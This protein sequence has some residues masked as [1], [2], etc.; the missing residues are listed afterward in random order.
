MPF[1]PV[2]AEQYQF[3]VLLMQCE[4][5]FYHTVKTDTSLIYHIVVPAGVTLPIL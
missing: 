1:S 5:V 4:V 3:Y 2:V